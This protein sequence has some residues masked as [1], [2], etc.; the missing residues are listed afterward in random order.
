MNRKTLVAV[1]W[2]LNE[3]DFLSVAC[4]ESKLR[5]IMDEISPQR[6]GDLLVTFPEDLITFGILTELKAAEIEA[7]DLNGALKQYVKK[8]YWQ[9]FKPRLKIGS[10][11]GAVFY[12][13]RDLMEEYFA[14][15]KKAA[16]DYSCSIIAGSGIVIQGRAAYNESRGYDQAGLGIVQRKTH[17]IELESQGGLK[18]TSAPLN[19]LTH[20]GTEFGRVAITI[21]FDGFQ[22]VVWEKIKNADIVVQPSA[23]P[24]PWTKEQQTDW[25]KSAFTMVQ[26]VAPV[27]INPMLTGN[28][29]GLE[30]YGQSSILVRGEDNNLGYLE[31]ET[32]PHFVQVAKSPLKEE[33]LVAYL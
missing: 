4:F 5:R 14:L 22:E 3:A 1:Q 21:C 7:S 30:F 23:N 28:I 29:L 6:V 2:R 18:L 16:N 11:V 8:K 19:N 26:S 27:V 9:L 17:L 32:L 15:F 10:W 13:C 20:W 12:N 31:T 33:I 25:L 24:G